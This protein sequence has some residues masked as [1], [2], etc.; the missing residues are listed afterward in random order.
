MI[1]LEDCVAGI[2]RIPKESIDIV[3][4]D[5]PYN[6]GVDFGNDSD[7]QEFTSYL[8]W[9]QEW[10]QECVRALKPTGTIYIYGF[11]EI[12]AHISVNF[13]LKHRW[14][15]WHYTNKNVPKAKFWVRSHESIL[16]GWKGKERIFNLDDVREPYTE[17]FLKNAAGKPRAATKGRFSNGNKETVYA[18]H[19]GGALPR[20]VIKVAALAGGA[21]RKEKYTYC[22]DCEKLITNKKGHKELNLISHPTQKPYSLTEKLLLAAKPSTGGK[23]LIP[24]AG[25]GSECKVARDLGMEFIAFEINPDYVN[26]ANK[27][28]EE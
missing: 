10:I 23:V 9:C 25:S 27:I 5:G 24:F 20:D 3:L 6:I 12:L 7:K 28:I 11:S 14:L 1:Y 19:K 21:G 2:K 17:T 22:K 26:M 18:A 8:N 13:P 4:A 16:V 15:I